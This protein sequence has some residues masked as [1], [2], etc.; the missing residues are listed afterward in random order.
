MKDNNV[1]I[2]EVNIHMK[3]IDELVAAQREVDAALGKLFVV[4]LQGTL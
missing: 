3:E 2:D 4:L 1:S